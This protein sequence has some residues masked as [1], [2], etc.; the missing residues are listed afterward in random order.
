M[1]KF[2][3]F[4][5]NFSCTFNATNISYHIT[6]RGISITPIKSFDTNTTME[7]PPF[8]QENTKGALLLVQRVMEQVYGSYDLPKKWKPNPYQEGKGRYLW[9]DAF[10]VFNFLNLYHETK[11]P[12]FLEMAEGLI[13][14]VHNVLGKTR[15]GNKR[16][17][18][19]TDEHP[20]LGGLRIGKKAP[21]GEA[22]GDGQYFHYLTK[23]MFALNRMSIIKQDPKYNQWA[24]ELA[25]SIHPHFVYEIE[26]SFHMF[27]KMNI[28]LQHALIRAEGNLDP[29]DG[30]VTYRILQETAQNKNVLSKEIEQFKQMVEHKYP[31][32]YSE[33]SLDTGEALC[34]QHW[35]PSEPWAQT[36][37]TRSLESISFMF[38]RGL[39]SKD[40]IYRLAF[41]EFGMSMGLQLTDN[42]DKRLKEKASEINRFWFNSIF[43]RDHDITP[44]MFCSSCFQGVLNRSY[45]QQH[46]IPNI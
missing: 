3:S 26:G 30:Y 46:T 9:T 33:D 32:F 8:P 10:G 15:D 17:G 44:V 31:K 11:D 29:Y 7:S 5:H 43:A 14:D 38:E 28:N 1:L 35:Y 40:N 20:L 27:W 34:L 36:V 2:K 41:R 37:R 4:R 23:W 6:R 13:Q 16:L 45:L 39:Y 24:I 22:D 21:E 18:N 42:I 25:Q 19:A 12:K